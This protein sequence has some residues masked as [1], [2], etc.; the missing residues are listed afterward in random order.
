MTPRKPEPGS[1]GL[2][3]QLHSAAIHLLRQLRKEDDASGLSAPRLSAL[4]VV[5]FGGPLTLGQLAAAEQVKP[6][7]MTRIVTGLEKEGLVKRIGDPRDRRLTRIQATIKGQKVL[8]AGRARRVE[9]LAAAV[10]D[11]RRSELAELT[12]GVH[13]LQQLIADLRG[14]P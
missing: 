4:S 7:T 1:E 5:V 10:R 8:T 14:T 2:A 12:R 13:L 11:L 3:D 9:K 6:P